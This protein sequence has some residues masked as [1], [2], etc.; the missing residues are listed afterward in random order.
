MTDEAAYH[1]K[2]ATMVDFDVYRSPMGTSLLGRSMYI[3][4]TGTAEPGATPFG[5]R[6]FTCTNPAPSIQPPLA[7]RRDATLGQVLTLL[8]SLDSDR[9]AVRRA[10]E[11][12][13]ANRNGRPG[14]HACRYT[15]VDL[16]ETLESRSV[17]KVQNLSQM[18]PDHDSRRN[19]TSGVQSRGID[20]ESLS[21]NAG[22]VRSPPHVQYRHAE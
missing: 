1:S 8:E 7:D 16:I 2:I 19:D 15:H 3:K 4:R 12:G 17:T 11:I 10:T 6:K 22:I 9:Y 20:F 13:Q 5:T 21:R 14:H 18:P